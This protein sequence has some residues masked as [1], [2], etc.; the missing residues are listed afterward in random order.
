MS[1]EPIADFQLI[2][3]SPLD[4]YEEGLAFFRGEGMVNRTVRRLHE[5]LERCGIDYAV[6]GAL[7]LNLHGYRR[8]T[9]DIDLLMTPEGLKTFR[10]TLVGNGYIA[11]FPGAMKKY[12]SAEG[13]VPIDI[14][15]SGEYPGDGLPKRVEFPEPAGN[16][17][18]IDGIKTLTLEKLVELKLASG[19]TA[20]DRR[21]DLA[22]VQELA[23]VK[24]LGADFARHLDESVRAEYLQIHREIEQAHTIR[25]GRGRSL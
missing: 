2:L 3:A 15:V 9:H 18:I 10:E 24:Q 23:K 25:Q 14:A 11:A 6:I 22:D 8:F 19:M 21:K 7:A 20:P 17:V 4:A 1:P 13:N 5:D 12:R 16:V